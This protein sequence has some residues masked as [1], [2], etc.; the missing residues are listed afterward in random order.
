MPTAVPSEKP[1]AAIK[2]K[3]TG[4]GDFWR[5]VRGGRVEKRRKAPVKKALKKS[6]DASHLRKQQHGT[7]QAKVGSILPGDEDETTRASRD[8]PDAFHDGPPTMPSS[9]SHS[10]FFSRGDKMAFTSLAKRPISKESGKKIPASKAGPILVN[11]GQGFVG[12]AAHRALVTILTLQQDS[13]ALFGGPNKMVPKT[14]EAAESYR[15]HAESYPLIT[16]STVV[17]TKDGVP[18]LYFLKD[19]MLAGLTEEEKQRLPAQSLSAI[20]ALIDV[21]PPPPP[22]K[23][24]SRVTEEQRVVQLAKKQAYGRYVSC[25][26]Q[27][28]GQQLT[29]RPVS[30]LLEKSRPFVQ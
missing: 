1:T 15:L 22:E 9:L 7:A 14:N 2:M 17:K 5:T 11:D 18:L 19:G 23:K 16:S 13:S 3:Q 26:H 30:L 8:R 25:F 20:R 10:G 12:Q 27:L 6:L 4:L 21:Y 28:L 29:H 24:D